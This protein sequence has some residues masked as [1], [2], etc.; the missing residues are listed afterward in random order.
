MDGWKKCP[1]CRG[2]VIVGDRE[3]YESL[4][5]RF[6]GACLQAECGDLDCGCKLYVYSKD[7]ETGSYADMLELLRAK[8]NRRSQ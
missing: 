7:S 6:G 1:F 5:K 8:W 3:S 2:E 4:L